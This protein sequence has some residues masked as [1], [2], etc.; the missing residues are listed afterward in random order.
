[1]NGWR[2]R[3]DSFYL[4][5]WGR[6]V[7]TAWSDAPHS[8]EGGATV[9]FLVPR[10]GWMRNHF[11]VYCSLGDCLLRVRCVPAAGCGRMPLAVGMSWWRWRCVSSCPRPLVVDCWRCVRFLCGG[12]NPLTRG[13]TAVRWCLCEG[14]CGVAGQGDA[15]GCI[16]VVVLCSNQRQE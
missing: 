9:E 6:H 15:F 7:V 3:W 2:E 1:M 8:I 12:P 14:W 4:R 10:R 13:L 11:H 5:V 16:L